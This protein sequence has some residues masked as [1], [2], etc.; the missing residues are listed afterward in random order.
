MP[1][2]YT[3][4][5]KNRCITKSTILMLLVMVVAIVAWIYVIENTKH[6][7]QSITIDD[8]H[9]IQNASDSTIVAEAQIISISEPVWG[10]SDGNSTMNPN[11]IEDLEERDIALTRF[12][13]VTFDVLNDYKDANDNGKRYVLTEASELGGEFSSSDS[14]SYHGNIGDIGLLFAEIV[15]DDVDIDIMRQ[16]DLDYLE[17]VS[18]TKFEYHMIYDLYWI[19]N[20]NGVGLDGFGGLWGQYDDIKNVIVDALNK[21]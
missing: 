16:K 6:T 17:S 15:S 12:R 19:V 18:D 13:Y 7:N 10:T 20:D 2:L 8:I 9:V 5:Y 11:D 4:R 3:L 14:A 1:N 21:T